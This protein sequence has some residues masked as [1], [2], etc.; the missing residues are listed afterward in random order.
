MSASHIVCGSLQTERQR[1]GRRK[2]LRPIV[3][4]IGTSNLVIHRGFIT[5]FSSIPTL[6]H[7]VVRWSRV[8]IAGV[9]HDYLY[10]RGALS[11]WQADWVWFEIARSGSHCAN[12]VQAFACWLALRLFGW[13]VWCKAVNRR[14]R[15]AS[16]RATKAAQRRGSI[17][18]ASRASS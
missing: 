17:D 6:L 16:R 7:W 1:D 4:D 18:N 11:R 5:D 2:L 9:V 10:A 14:R 12:L 13:C 15:A 3:V 8:D